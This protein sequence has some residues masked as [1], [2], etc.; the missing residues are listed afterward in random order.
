M[1]D[2][3]AVRASGPPGEPSAEIITILDDDND[4]FARGHDTGHSDHGAPRW[5]VPVAVLLVPLLLAAAAL[6]ALW[7]PGKPAEAEA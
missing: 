1:R 5:L 6:H 4:V 2:T 7:R 3:W